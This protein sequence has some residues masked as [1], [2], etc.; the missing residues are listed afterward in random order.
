MGLKS[1]AARWL[2]NKEV[3]KT[4]KWLQNATYLQQNT[5]DQLI[6]VLQHTAFGKD[7]A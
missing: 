6:Q 4:T 1:A 3:N 2:A 7:H 5:F